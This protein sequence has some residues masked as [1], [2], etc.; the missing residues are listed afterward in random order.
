MSESILIPKTRVRNKSY[1]FNEKFPNL[2]HRPVEISR[3]KNVRDIHNCQM[4][5]VN[6]EAALSSWKSINN[7]KVSQVSRE[8][9]SA[10]SR[11]LRVTPASIGTLPHNLMSHWLNS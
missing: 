10:V 7:H 9:R 1:D 5:V 6:M 3:T 4:S 8:Y 11:S 2:G